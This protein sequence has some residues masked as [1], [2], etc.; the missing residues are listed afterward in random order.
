[1][2][3]TASGGSGGDRGHDRWEDRNRDD[4]WRRDKYKWRNEW[5]NDDDEDDL[6]DIDLR[7]PV[8]NDSIYASLLMYRICQ[9][10]LGSFVFAPQAMPPVQGL[11]LRE[12]GPLRQQEV[13]APLRITMYV[14]PW[15]RL[16]E[17]LPG[18]LLSFL[19]ASWSGGS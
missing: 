18:C 13:R 4:E 5:H 17:L 2:A 3:A 10:C 14:T 8:P 11:G 6:P 9:Q 16:G 15:F 7:R 1:M 19:G 12:E